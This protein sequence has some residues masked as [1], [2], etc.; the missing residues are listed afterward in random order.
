MNFPP[1]L[2][3][4]QMRR[5]DAE[6]VRTTG[7]PSLILMENAGRAVAEAVRVRRPP[8]G[9]QPIVVCVAC[10]AGNNGGD[11]FVVA[12]H[13]AALSSAEGTYQVRVLLAV[14]RAK[15]SGDAAA[16]F[17]ALERLSGVSVHDHAAAAKDDWA[18]ALAGA[19]VIVDALLGTGLRDD[20]RGTVAAAIAAINE[21][22]ALTVAVDVP[23]G[24]DADTGRPRGAAVRADVTVT[25]GARKLGLAIDAS[26][27]CGDVEVA[28]LG[29]PIAVPDGTGPAAFWIDAPGVRA[30]LPGRG[31]T[32]YKGDAGHLLLIA[33][34]PGKTG[35][36]WLAAR[37]ALRTGAGLV[38]IASTAAGQVALDT[39]VIEEMTARYSGGE[40]ADGGSF[41][42][43]EAM[44]ARPHVRALALGP[45]IPTGPGMRALVERLVEE[46]KVPL[47]LD[48][49][50]LNLLGDRGARMLSAAGAPRV[51]TP[52][53]GEMARLVGRPTAD[54]QQARVE[55]ARTFAAASNAVVVLKGPRTLI[56]APDGAVFVNPAIEPALGTAGSGDVLTGVIGALLAQGMAPLEAAI[57]GV[58]LHGRAGA[59]VGRTH[60]APGAIAGDLPEAVA[61]VRLSLDAAV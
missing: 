12:R 5:F 38:T 3:T 50:G 10:G 18:S 55:T 42:A 52:H 27:A 16:M 19:E 39:K 41:A 8:R 51:V 44:L 48:A 30:L 33:G 21:A 47:V 46:V 53:P 25:M 36:A 1:L 4:A 22:A 31:G 28:E 45:G 13:L 9:G 58:F 61:S 26:G 57:A 56:A 14:E 32:D 20:V 7:L 54:I 24:T 2:S 23:S 17:R 15:L 35:S 6:V 49:D 11:G 40:D 37:A 59:L 60:G 43:I 34:S 29:V